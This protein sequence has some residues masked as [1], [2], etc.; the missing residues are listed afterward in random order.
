MKNLLTDITQTSQDTVV[1]DY[2]DSINARLSLFF[3]DK[4][5][6]IS[7]FFAKLKKRLKEGE[8]QLPLTTFQIRRMDGSIQYALESELAEI[9]DFLKLRESV[10]ESSN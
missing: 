2:T 7:S 5:S 4:D 8:I 10:E 1:Q 6:S 9:N 3:Y